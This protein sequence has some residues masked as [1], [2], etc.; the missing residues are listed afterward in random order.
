[1]PFLY[2]GVGQ[3]NLVACWCRLVRA[4]NGC[5]FI[6]FDRPRCWP[7]DNISFAGATKMT[8]RPLIRPGDLLKAVPE[9]VK[10]GFA[11][12]VTKDGV[13]V[14][15]KGAAEPKDD[16]SEVRLGK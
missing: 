14:M 1:M 8:T 16:F 7:C 10:M 6:P 12:I 2:S 5:R 3:G 11:V 9:W 4:W 13:K 15:P